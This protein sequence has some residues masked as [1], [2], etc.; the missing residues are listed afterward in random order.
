MLAWIKRKLINLR[1]YN[2]RI[3]EVN[4]LMYLS[5]RDTR[6]AWMM[7]SLDN[8][9]MSDDICPLLMFSTERSRANLNWSP[10]VRREP[11]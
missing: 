10:L 5:D 3:T 7:V 11:A 8:F 9:S 4:K 2:R 6:Q 1:S